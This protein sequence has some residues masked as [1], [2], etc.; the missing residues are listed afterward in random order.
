M[1]CRQTV[2]G[3]TASKPCTTHIRVKALARA[4]A[5]VLA[6][7]QALVKALA[8]V[9]AQAVALTQAQA[10]ALGVTSEEAPWWDI[11]LVVALAEAPEE[12]GAPAAVRH[13]SR[14]SLQL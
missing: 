11:F 10:Q 1:H 7:A 9:L 3:G 13:S 8:L 4:L 12:G 6:Q 14:S 5:L 2:T